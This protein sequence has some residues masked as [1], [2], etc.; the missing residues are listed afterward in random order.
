MRTTDA[1]NVGYNIG[2]CWKKINLY[3]KTNRWDDALNP[4]M[5]VGNYSYQFLSTLEKQRKCSQS[6]IDSEGFK[7]GTRGAPIKS[8]LRKCNGGQKWVN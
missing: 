1:F 5:P 4:L 6:T 2:E 7:G 8:W 3:T